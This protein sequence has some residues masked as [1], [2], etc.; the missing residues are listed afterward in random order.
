MQFETF[1]DGTPFVPNLLECFKKT[2]YPILGDWFP[3]DQIKSFL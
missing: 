1:V 2:L 3:I